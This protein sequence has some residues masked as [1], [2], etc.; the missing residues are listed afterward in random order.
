MAGDGS[1]GRAGQGQG[2]SPRDGGRDGGI[3]WR[4]VAK[5]L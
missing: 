2:L 5:G 3:D 4:M 1:G